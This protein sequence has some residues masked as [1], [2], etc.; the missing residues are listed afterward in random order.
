MEYL[1]L[2]IFYFL[3]AYQFILVM[4]VLMTWFPNFRE[5][6]LFRLVARLAEP[7][8]SRFRRLI[9]PIGMVDLSPLIG[10]LLLSFAISGFSRLLVSGTF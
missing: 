3:R 8:L 10:F 6:Q 4:Y 9:P 1:L 5:S 2:G 7:Y